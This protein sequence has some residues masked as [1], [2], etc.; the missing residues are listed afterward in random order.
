MKV[1]YA[2]KLITYRVWQL[3][4]KVALLVTRKNSQH[5]YW[6]TVLQ[7]SFGS[8]RCAQKNLSRQEI[9]PFALS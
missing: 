5:F 1:I 7:H 4:Q 2:E 6:K 8:A 3:L 9:Y